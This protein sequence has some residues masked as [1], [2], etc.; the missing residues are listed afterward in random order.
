ITASISSRFDQ[1]ASGFCTGPSHPGRVLLRLEVGL[2][3]LQGYRS[4]ARCE[5]P[6]AGAPTGWGWFCRGTRPGCEPMLREPIVRPAPPA[7]GL[8][9]SRALSVRADAMLRQCP[10]HMLAHQ[11]RGVR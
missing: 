8:P 9:G 4:I 2:A 1:S 3:L 6:G 7:K 10:Y 11:F 5:T